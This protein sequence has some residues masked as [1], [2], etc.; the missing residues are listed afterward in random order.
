MSSTS[1][2]RCLLFQLSEDITKDELNSFKFLLGRELPKCRQNPEAI[3]VRITL[4]LFFFL[5]IITY[6]DI[7]VVRRRTECHSSCGENTITA[8]CR[9]GLAASAVPLGPVYATV[10][11]S[12]HSS[13][14]AQCTRASPVPGAFMPKHH[15]GLGDLG[16]WNADS[17]ILPQRFSSGCFLS[18]YQTQKVTHHGYYLM[19]LSFL[20]PNSENKNLSSRTLSRPQ[21]LEFT[22]SLAGDPAARLLSQPAVLTAGCFV[23][24]KTLVAFSLFS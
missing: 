7:W 15:L 4:T 17:L 3:T 19:L 22:R 18:C 23:L 21:S 16:Q 13:V 12:C 5:N 14:T 1:P 24:M 10:R 9:K 2:S 20:F 6:G 8:G 11:R